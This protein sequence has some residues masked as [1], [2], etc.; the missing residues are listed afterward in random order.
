M[1]EYR[2]QMW[3]VNENW[4]VV[5]VSVVAVILIEVETTIV[6]TNGKV[7]YIINFFVLVYIFLVLR[8]TRWRLLGII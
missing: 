3:S 7:N 8:K 1:R 6:E 4:P 5:V 2:M